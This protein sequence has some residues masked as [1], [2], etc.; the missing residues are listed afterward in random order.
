MSHLYQVVELKKEATFQELSAWYYKSD[1]YAPDLAKFN[2]DNGGPVEAATGKLAAFQKV[3]FPDLDYFE[4]PQSPAA[5]V[6]PAANP[7]PMGKVYTAYEVFTGGES[8]LTIAHGRVDRA[9]EIRSLNPN[10]VV[11]NQGVVPAGT[12]LKLPA[13]AQG[14]VAPR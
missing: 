7:R 4:K 10:V 14:G 12:L 13:D 1:K 8:W 5:E 11:N 6:R 2:R 3:Y 9:D